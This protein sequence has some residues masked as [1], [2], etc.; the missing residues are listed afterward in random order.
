MHLTWEAD[1][2]V[3]IVEYLAE[4]C[5]KKDARTIS[6]DTEVP[7][8]FALKILHKL[9]QHKIVISY[10]GAKGGY[11][12]ASP[13]ET[14]TLRQVIEAVEGPYV[15]SRCQLEPCRCT[16]AACRFHK[17][18]EEISDLVRE[19]LDSYTFSQSCSEKSGGIE[20]GNKR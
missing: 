16:N 15:I 10:K 7:Q 9:L 13:P 4:S 17:I 11:A 8:R 2:A 14:I 19:R 12:L 20:Q 6:A 3:R 1:Y 5:Q 18:Y